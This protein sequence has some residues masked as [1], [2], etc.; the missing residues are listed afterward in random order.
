MG[1]LAPVWGCFSCSRGCFANAQ[2]PWGE[3]QDFEDD[4]ST[5]TAYK[6]FREY[7]AL[8]RRYHNQVRRQ[9]RRERLMRCLVQ[10]GLVAL[11]SAA[12]IWAVFSYGPAFRP[13]L[14]FGSSPSVSQVRSFGYF[15]TCADARAAGAAPLRRASPVIRP[16]LM[17]TVTGSRASGPGGTGFGSGSECAGEGA[18]F[19]VRAAPMHGLLTLVV[20]KRGCGPRLAYACQ[21]PFTSLG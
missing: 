21:T 17:R 11:G 19:Y 4:P 9:Q 14:S 18:S 13:L 5:L 2:S 3:P 8:N 1:R 10:P 7:R 20:G 6:E 15:R 16:A 12:V